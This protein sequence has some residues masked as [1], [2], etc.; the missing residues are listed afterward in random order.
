MSS[1]SFR[2]PP[3]TVKGILRE[4]GPGLII[5]G[6]VVGSGEL[7]A[8]TVTGAE[9]GFWLMWIILIGCVIKVF[10]QLEIGKCTVLS[11]QTTLRSLS[12][13][14][15]WMPGGQHW[16]V[17]LIL[18]M[19][20]SSI[21]QMGGV[22]GGVGQAFSISFPITEAG[23]VYNDASATQLRE[24][25]DAAVSASG[26][27]T[28]G[29]F[30]REASSESPHTNKDLPSAGRDVY[31]WS[32]VISAVTMILLLR[33]RYAL[34]EKVVMAFVV[35]FTVISIGNIFMLQQTTFWSVGWRDLAQ[36]LSFRLPP[37]VPGVY[38][39]TTALATFGIIGMAAGE[40]IFYP[41]WCIEKG[42]AKFVGP[43]QNT[44]EWNERAKGWLRVMQ[45]DAWCSMVIY[46][47]S[48]LAFY[49]LGAAVLNRIGLQPQGME[50][51]R[52]LAAMY[53]PVFGEWTSCVFLIGAVAVLFS[54]F[55]VN[56]AS[57][58]LVWA[59]AFFLF[60]GK[61]V[62][63]G[64]DRRVRSVLFVALP[65]LSFIMYC[66]FS[67]PKQLIIMAGMLQTLMLPI[68]SYVALSFR[69][70]QVD[71]TFRPGRVSDIFL[72]ISSFALL[73]AG[74][75]LALTILFPAVRELG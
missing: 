51:I 47:I 35:S 56:I 67:K 27:D 8:T 31:Y 69:Y 55:F 15:G 9:A 29:A 59:D 72:W 28:E 43:R 12:G 75:W 53:E 54:T 36:G 23:R 39:I 74:A 17:W 1:D 66:F 44:R 40:L 32:F 57:A 58:S 63:D 60:R 26:L 41:Y 62:S 3:E 61:E 4:L 11:G 2:N 64:N 14:G 68:L 25:I 42:Y 7:I 38:P 18:L 21:G 6:S 65:T 5:A 52:S 45:W 13:I 48:T 20:F 46:T 22:L 33:G 71:E 34:F 73:L 10:V 37:K 19:M 70:K 49:F 50:M 16:I 24:K 30:A